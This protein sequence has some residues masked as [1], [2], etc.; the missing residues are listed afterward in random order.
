MTKREVG[1]LAFKLM[2]IYALVLCAA[3]ALY[4]IMWAENIVKVVAGRPGHELNMA[5]IWTGLCI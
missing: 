2:G 3:Q 4:V 1:S 5:D